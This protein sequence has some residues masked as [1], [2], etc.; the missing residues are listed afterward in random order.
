MQLMKQ[1]SI[2]CGLDNLEI[3]QPIEWFNLEMTLLHFMLLK[4]ELSSIDQIFYIQTF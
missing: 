1:V 2:L 3:D 4:M